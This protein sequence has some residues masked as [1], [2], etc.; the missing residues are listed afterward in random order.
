MVDK[1]LNFASA[2]E[3]TDWLIAN[4]DHFTTARRFGH[5]VDRQ[6]HPTLKH[7]E[8][9]AKVLLTHHPKPVM[10]YA[11]KGVEDTYVKTIKKG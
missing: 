9:H 5:Q 10:I 3:R 6:E 8:E 4:A 11:V 1:P 2:Q 7:A